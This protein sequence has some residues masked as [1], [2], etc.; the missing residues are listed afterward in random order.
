MTRKMMEARTGR[1]RDS[2]EQGPTASKRAP[3]TVREN[4]SPVAWHTQNEFGS[5]E[6][7]VECREKRW[8]EW[9]A[10]EKVR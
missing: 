10:V 8:R 1:P 2:G 6:V 7:S 5:V 4:Q 3:P 9:A